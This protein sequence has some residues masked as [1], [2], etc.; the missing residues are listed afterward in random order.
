MKRLN[1]S[2]SFLLDLLRV[3]A[4]QLV[5]IGHGLS[6]FK[7][8]N[9]PY[10]QNTAV[11]LFFILSG[12]VISYSVFLKIEKNSSYGFRHFFIDRFS[13]IYTALIPALI[14]I[15]AIDSVA[16]VFFKDYYSY[17]NAFNVRTFIGNLLMLQDF[18]IFNLGITSF[19]SARV[20]W[21][22]AIEWWLYMTF[23]LL[24]VHFF[25]GFQRKY[26]ILLLFFMIVPLHNSFAGRGDALSL[27][28]LEGAIVTIILFR[29][30]RTLNKASSLFFALIF[31][32][33]I[34][35]RILKTHEAYDLVYV[36]L[37]T[38]FIIFSLS[39]AS[40]FSFPFDKLKLFIKLMAG[41][42]FTL[43]LIHYSIFD[44]ISIWYKSIDGNKHSQVFIASFFI[45]H[46][47]SIILAFYT[48]MRYRDVKI[49]LIHRIKYFR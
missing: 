35:L 21:T 45:S 6:Y 26:L 10:I 2:Q 18:P 36:T 19:G 13:R 38:M 8:T 12:I 41:Y 30:H 46:F 49:F 11:V 47:L 32:C 27:F 20:L 3:I 43:F 34:L 23:G 24:V 48:E 22:L 5:V 14:F 15:I 29:G 42:S 9:A 4:V 17:V 16:I 28:W 33:L 37:I 40:Y 25:S 7:I 31:A 1:D 39:Y 44:F